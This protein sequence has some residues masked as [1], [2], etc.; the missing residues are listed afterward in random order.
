MRFSLLKNFSNSI[1]KVMNNLYRHDFVDDCGVNY[2]GTTLHEND[3][4]AVA[5]F[6]SL[7]AG[8]K[9]K[10][11]SLKKHDGRLIWFDLRNSTANGVL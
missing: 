2:V 9:V 1:G 5:Y 6:R 8:G 10:I 7:E 11:K 3:E 4:E